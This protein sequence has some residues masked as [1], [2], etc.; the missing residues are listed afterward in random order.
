M[1][2]NVVTAPQASGVTQPAGFN[3]VIPVEVTGLVDIGRL[4]RELQALDEDMLSQELRA[5]GEVKL[6]KTSYLLDKMAQ[7]NQLD[8]SNK[9][10]RQK[11]ITFLKDARTKAPQLHISFG[12][13]PSPA[14]L[15]KLVAWMRRE[16]HPHILIS[17]GLQPNIGVGC[18]L[19]SSNKYFDM[20]LREEMLSKRSILLQ[21]LQEMTAIP[22]LASVPPPQATLASSRA[23]SATV[24]LPTAKTPPPATTVHQTVNKVPETTGAA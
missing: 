18:T 24:A 21:K 17:V 6:P 4:V 2:P 11:L 19:R 10:D 9:A 1:V 20:S 22:A 7:Q 8:F 14:F 5:A 3:P 16:I 15:E 23:S 12:T 13:D